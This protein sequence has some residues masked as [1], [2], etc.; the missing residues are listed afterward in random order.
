[1]VLFLSIEQGQCS[2]S[3]LQSQDENFDRDG[4]L[5]EDQSI[6]LSMENES[7]NIEPSQPLDIANF[8]SSKNFHDFS[9][10]FSSPRK[11]SDFLENLDNKGLRLL[12]SLPQI[13]TARLQVIDPALASRVLQEEDSIS[14][15]EINQPI[16]QPREPRLSE[17][18]NSS[19]LVRTVG[20]SL[21]LDE[22]RLD[23]GRGVTLAVLDSGVDFSHPSL[24]H[25]D[26]EQ[27]SLIQS[28]ESV[29][30]A[31]GHGTA[32]SSIISGITEDFQ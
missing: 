21:G 20:E 29:R 32:I 4:F 6:M 18:I 22:E 14:R 17:K 30:R 5:K 7:T 25:V 31:N 15:L 10:R 16:Y 8:L 27:I 23:W 3:T 9:L 28:S 11:M 13:S 12:S 24:S 19:K 26:H 2:K 1:M